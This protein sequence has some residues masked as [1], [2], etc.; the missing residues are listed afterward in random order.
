ME[1]LEKKNTM[2]DMKNYLDRLTR[3]LDIAGEKDQ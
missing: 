3:Q 2:S 1:F